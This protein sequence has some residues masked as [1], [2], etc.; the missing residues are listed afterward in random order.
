MCSQGWCKPGGVLGSFLW[1]RNAGPRSSSGWTRAADL[2]SRPLQTQQVGLLV[3]S[4][5]TQQLLR[6]KQFSRKQALH[7]L[8]VQTT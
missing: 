2:E 3:G 7:F 6:G 4:E 1:D 5:K 8:L